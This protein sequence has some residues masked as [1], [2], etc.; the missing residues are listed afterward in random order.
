MISIIAAPF[1]PVSYRFTG[2]G[3]GVRVKGRVGTHG[4][5]AFGYCTCSSFLN[6]KQG[7]SHPRS[8]GCS[9]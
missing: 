5:G 9:G 4:Q 8:P 6:F 1:S 7:A 3:G 2:R